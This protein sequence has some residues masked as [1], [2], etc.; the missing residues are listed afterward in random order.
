MFKSMITFTFGLGISLF[1][2]LLQPVYAEEDDAAEESKTSMT[3]IPLDPPFVVNFGPGS[4]VRFLQ[5]T[6][7]LGTRD[8]DA[9]EL[10]KHNRPAIRNN[11]VF[12]FS[13]QDASVL[14]TREG[15]SKLRDDALSEARQVIQKEVGKD[16]IDTIY[17]TSFV[18]Q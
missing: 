16:G 7:E 10:I 18:M 14:E 17:F 9:V 5:V 2:L 12:L 15:K 8:A 1:L 11:L 6:V 3:Y 13:D 4:T